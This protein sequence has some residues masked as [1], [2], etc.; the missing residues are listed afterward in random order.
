M[1]LGQKLKQARLEAG[2]SQRQLCADTITRNML[3][4]IENG[5]AKPS[6]ATLQ[7]LCSRLG[8]PISYFWEDAPSEN[9]GLLKQAAAATP[10]QAF[11]LLKGYL[12]PDP[13]LDEGYYLLLTRCCLA[14]ARQALAEKRTVYAQSL[15]QQAE[16]AC[17]RA[18]NLGEMFRRQLTLLQYQAG[19][20]VPSALAAVLPDNTEE[21]ELRAKAALEQK[22]PQKCLSYLAAADRQTQDGILLR[23]DALM[24]CKDYQNAAD[25]FGTLESSLPHQVYS[26]LE[27][28]YREMGDFQKAYE[29]A[30]KQR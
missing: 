9:L 25:C 12:S 6:L 3:S 16:A 24:Q 29:Y 13:L 11:S 28:C 23:G 2:L 20:A 4:Q 18:G 8:K 17:E 21:M 1:E 19:M 14:L 26:R 7:A 22:D 10:E 27:I 30:C 15:I 5:S